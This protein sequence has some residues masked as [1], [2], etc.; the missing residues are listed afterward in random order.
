MS[1]SNKH[2]NRGVTFFSL[3][4]SLRRFP[5]LSFRFSSQH[6]NIVYNIAVNYSTIYK[7]HHQITSM[8]RNSILMILISGVTIENVR[9]R[10]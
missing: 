3:S 4:L 5:L 7:S 1:K 8:E 6:T 9:L 10:R 2:R